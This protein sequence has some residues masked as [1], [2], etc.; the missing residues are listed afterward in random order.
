[1]LFSAVNLVVECSC[2]SRKLLNCVCTE[3]DWTIKGELTTEF[4]CSVYVTIYFFKDLKS[5]Y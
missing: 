2:H 4:S 1:M 5:L 3:Q